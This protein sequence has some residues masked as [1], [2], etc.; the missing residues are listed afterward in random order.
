MSLIP[1]VIILHARIKY[2]FNKISNTGRIEKISNFHV[3]QFIEKFAV[4]KEVCLKQEGPA[5]DK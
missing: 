1:V 4:V 3:H 2:I 5:V